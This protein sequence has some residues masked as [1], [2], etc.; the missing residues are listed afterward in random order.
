MPAPPVEHR[1][2]R[3]DG[4]PARERLDRLAELPRARLR[5]TEIDEALHVL[6][7]GRE[8]RLG[9]RDRSGVDL[10][11]ILDARGRPVLHGLA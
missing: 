3:R 2:V 4:Q 8:R 1:V 10:R 11:P 9:T 7:I 6:R 5:D